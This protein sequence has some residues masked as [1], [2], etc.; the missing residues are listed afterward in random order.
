MKPKYRFA[1]ALNYDAK[2]DAPTVSVKGE[3]L[4]ADYIVKIARQYGVPVEERGELA[5]L[6]Q[7]VEV[8]Q[9]IPQELYEIVAVLFH[10]L[11]KRKL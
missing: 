10:E 11:D 1:A 9:E 8:D 5:E 3:D 7:E 4:D 2:D 6:L